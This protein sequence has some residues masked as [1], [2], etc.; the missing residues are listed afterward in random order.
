MDSEMNGNN[1]DPLRALNRLRQLSAEIEQGLLRDDLEIVCQAAALLGPTLTQWN[2]AHETLEVGA[3]D[4]A[5]LALE[6]RQTLTRCEVSI[7]KTMGRMSGELR[8]LRQGRQR[9]QM[10]RPPT[11]DSSLRLEDLMG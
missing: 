6:T 1:N 4:A 9:M 7:L 8:G 5:Q 11:P 2:D 10:R 3:G